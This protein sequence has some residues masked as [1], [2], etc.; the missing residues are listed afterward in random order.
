M[1]K[2]RFIYKIL[3]YSWLIGLGVSCA[4]TEMDKLVTE[5]EGGDIILSVST[6]LSVSRAVDDTAIESRLDTLDVFFGI[7]LAIVRITNVLQGL[8]WPMAQ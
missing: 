8:V 5:A 3:L 4:D 1:I 7:K 2:M 6:G